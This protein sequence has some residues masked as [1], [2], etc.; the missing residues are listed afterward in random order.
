MLKKT[1]SNIE[2]YLNPMLKTVSKSYTNFF[3]FDDNA[4]LSNYIK[5]VREKVVNDFRFEEKAKKLLNKYLDFLIEFYK[6]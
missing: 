1:I 2:K 5:K 3:L 6:E 4:T